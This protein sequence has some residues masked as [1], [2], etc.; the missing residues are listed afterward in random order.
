[1]AHPK[2]KTNGVAHPSKA[3]VRATSWT[4]WTVGLFIVYWLCVFLDRIK[5][6][7]RFRLSL[8]HGD[9]RSLLIDE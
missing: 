9:M 3:P 5:V 4:K 8:S 2:A 1:M 6:G 7:A